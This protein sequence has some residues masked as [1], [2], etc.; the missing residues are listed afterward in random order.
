MLQL[1]LENLFKTGLS[2]ADFKSQADKIPAYLQQIH[3]RKPT[4]NI[5]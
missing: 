2:E 1:N 3:A 4:T 5:L